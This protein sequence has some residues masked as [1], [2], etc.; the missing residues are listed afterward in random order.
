MNNHSGVRS[1]Y[2][3]DPSQQGHCVLDPLWSQTVSDLATVIRVLRLPRQQLSVSSPAFLWW[4][5][6]LLRS[7]PALQRL[8]VQASQPFRSS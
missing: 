3:E 6:S 7:L 2:E 5:F 4:P 8:A 1:A